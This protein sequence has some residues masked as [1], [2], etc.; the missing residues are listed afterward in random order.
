MI[1]FLAHDFIKSTAIV[2]SIAIISLLVYIYIYYNIY[3]RPCEQY[4]VLQSLL[5]MI[6]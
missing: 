5:K 3:N 1:N 2:F 4:L 6:V